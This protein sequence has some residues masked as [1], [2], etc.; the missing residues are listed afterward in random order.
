MQKTSR[1]VQSVPDPRG[2]GVDLAAAR[3]GTGR[4]SSCTSSTGAP[5]PPNDAAPAPAHVTALPSKTA[6][7]P[8]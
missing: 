8:P 1:P 4:P 7:L 3:T 2:I 6:A 5:S